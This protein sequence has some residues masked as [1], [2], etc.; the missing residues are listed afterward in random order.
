M[1]KIIYN[2]REIEVPQGSNLRKALKAA[3]LSPHN[4]AAEWLNCK[5]MGTCGTCALEIVSAEVPPLNAREKW[6]LIFPPHQIDHGLRL[7][8]QLK[9]E[10]P[11]ILR[12][13][14]GFW[15]EK[16]MT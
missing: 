11:M 1:P 8:C 15:G 14:P 2:E 13:H 9:V 10:G 3:G 16:C 12:K 5:G 4:G 6:R 7:A